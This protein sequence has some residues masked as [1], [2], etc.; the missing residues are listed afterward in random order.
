MNKKIQTTLVSLISVIALT[1]FDQWTKWLAVEKLKDQAPYVLI[2]GVFE[3]NYTENR[4]AAFGMLQ[5]QRLF[6][7]IMT[8]IV[9]CGVALLFYRMPFERYYLPMRG[10]FVVFI[11]GTIGNLI[12]RV[13]LGY[14]VDFFYISLIDFPGF[15]VAELFIT[16]SLALFVI[17][18]LFRYKEE[19]LAFIPGMTDGEKK[20]Q[21]SKGTL[22]ED[23]NK[24]KDSEGT[25]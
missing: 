8:A 16:G 7:L 4:G 22:F 3:L 23:E 10:I 20:A 12:D 25:L 15:N 9:L 18:I 13:F 14:V 5:D 17:L 19:D 11:A 6:F 2:S 21:P 1:L 24:E